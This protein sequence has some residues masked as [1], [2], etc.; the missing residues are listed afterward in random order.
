VVALVVGLASLLLMGHVSLAPRDRI[1]G[2][3]SDP[4]GEVWRLA[5]FDRGE[6]G[7]VGNSV[8]DQAN[9]PSGVPLR[10]PADVSQVLYDVPAALSR[11]WSD[12]YSPITR[13]SF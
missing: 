3:P 4:L 9:A 12:P 8:S 11:G 2:L 5:Q 1:Y 10:R 13:S 6:I 7:L